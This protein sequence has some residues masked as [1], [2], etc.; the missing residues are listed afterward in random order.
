[1]HPSGRG[2]EVRNHVIRSTQETE[3]AEKLDR[4]LEVTGHAMKPSQPNAAIV[5]T[6]ANSNCDESIWNVL[7]V[8]SS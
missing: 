6:A 2:R 8:L 7:E 4:H 5:E 3:E 1:M